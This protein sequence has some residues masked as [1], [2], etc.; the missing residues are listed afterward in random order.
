MKRR[1]FYK[2]D[3]DREKSK[4]ATTVHKARAERAK[5]VDR[6]RHEKKRSPN[7]SVE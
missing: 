2:H 5:E 1:R 7:V 4:G 3:R 6:K